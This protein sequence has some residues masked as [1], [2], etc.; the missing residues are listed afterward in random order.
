MPTQPDRLDR[1]E[2][3]QLIRDRVTALDLT[4]HVVRL[5]AGRCPGLAADLA[6]RQAK[7]LA[8]LAD[9]LNHLDRQSD[10]DP[11]GRPAL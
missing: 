4:L 1:D 9:R 10:C 6:R 2:I 5:A 3:A 11:A 8:A 7:A